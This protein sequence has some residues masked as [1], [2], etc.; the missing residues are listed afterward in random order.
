MTIAEWALLISG[1]AFLASIGI[2]I[3][4]WNL[5]NAKSADS[6]R[7]LLLQRILET[8]SATFLNL[9]ELQHLLN[10]HGNNMHNL[11][12]NNLEALIPRMRV[13]HEELERYHAQWSN[14]KDGKKL[15]DIEKEI[16]KV[17]AMSAD[18][19]T[20]T[21]TIENGFKSYKNT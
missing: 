19:S 9:Y 17:N 16:S 12:R 11:Q 2:P 18:T 20:T 10:K 13:E 5:S 3:V 1:L 15:K 7:T 6:K 21:K 14:Y 4:Q 8:K